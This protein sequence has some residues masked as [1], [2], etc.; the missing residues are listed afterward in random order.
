MGVVVE[1]SPKSPK[2]DLE[3]NPVVS[4]GQNVAAPPPVGGPGGGHK[5]FI[6]GCAGPSQLG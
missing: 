3:S 1:M 4:V 5:F 6:R 2:G